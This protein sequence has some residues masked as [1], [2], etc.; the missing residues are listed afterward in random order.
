[1]GPILCQAE[2]K[3]RDFQVFTGRLRDAG[4]RREI[5][6]CFG[7]RKGDQPCE[8]SG[9]VAIGHFLRREIRNATKQRTFLGC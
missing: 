2:G 3:K 9:A 4:R 1:M 5:V 6:P 7:G 8:I